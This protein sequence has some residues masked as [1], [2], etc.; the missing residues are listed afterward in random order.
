MSTPLLK[1][2]GLLINA[3][4]PSGIK[5]IR[6][7]MEKDAEVLPVMCDIDHKTAALMHAKLNRENTL[8]GGGDHAPML[9]R[10]CHAQ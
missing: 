6:R 7:M 9:L 5:R 4:K 8:T 10:P 3:N 2:I 1:V